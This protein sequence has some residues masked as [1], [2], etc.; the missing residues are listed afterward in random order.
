MAANIVMEH[1][2]EVVPWCLLA[3]TLES[4]HY[5]GCVVCRQGGCWFELHVGQASLLKL[6]IAE[7]KE[8][9]ATVTESGAYKKTIESFKPAPPKEE[10]AAE[11]PK[12][13]AKA[14]ESAPAPATEKT[15]KQAEPEAE[16]KPDNVASSTPAA[17]AA[18]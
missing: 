8:L 14:E 7:A 15:P 11:T 17:T 1:S 13:E 2:S 4:G 16:N 10:K 18:A 12:E 9:S 3:E 6:K 5:G